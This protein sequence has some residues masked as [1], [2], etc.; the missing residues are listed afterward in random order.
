MNSR[1]FFQ[2]RNKVIQREMNKFKTVVTAIKCFPLFLI[3]HIVSKNV[4]YS[5]VYRKM[6]DV[7]EIE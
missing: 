1:S 3:F 5:I 7:F 2:S 4:A 6:D